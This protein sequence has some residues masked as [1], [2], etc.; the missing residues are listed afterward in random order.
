MI[1]P[2]NK[3]SAIAAR[4]LCE[5]IGRADEV[6]TPKKAG[7][8]PCRPRPSLE[9]GLPNPVLA[10]ELSLPAVFPGD[11]RTDWHW[12]KADQSCGKISAL[13]SI[14]HNSAFHKIQA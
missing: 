6:Q 12:S 11:G 2:R 9:S 5:P 13:L 4:K 3:R 10:G 14:I 1:D 7:L 8:A